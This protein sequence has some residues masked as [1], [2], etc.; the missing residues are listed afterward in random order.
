ME[1]RSVI[2]CL[3]GIDPSNDQ[4]P[5]AHPS[6]LSRTTIPKLHN[7]LVGLKHDGVRMFCLLYN[8]K[9]TFVNRAF[10]FYPAPVVSSDTDSYNGTL[11]DGELVNTDYIVFD[12]VALNGNTVTNRPYLERLILIRRFLNTLT[13][14]DISVHVK[15]WRVFSNTTIDI[16]ENWVNTAPLC[17]GL[18][19][20]DPNA[21]LLR[22][23]CPG[24]FKWKFH[25]TLDVRVDDDNTLWFRSTRA[26][27]INVFP[28]PDAVFQK[29]SIVECN[30]NYINNK[31]CLLPV[32]VRDDKTCE[33]SLFTVR[34]TLDIVKED[35]KINN[36]FL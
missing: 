6:T 17:D 34:A 30:V 13:S 28:H 26:D 19:F 35:L 14:T 27:K 29:N 33:N 22:G 36:L 3:W 7:Y 2:N 32:R 15:N 8:D 16:L 1:Q 11:L 31:W 4:L 23:T 5:C 25:N 21:C 24:S 20:Q 10:T 18:V 12:I 9:A